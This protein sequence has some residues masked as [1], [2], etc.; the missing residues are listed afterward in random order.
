MRFNVVIFALAAIAANL[1]F[2]APKK[3]IA[4]RRPAKAAPSDKNLRVQ[5]LLDRAHFS[6]G[7]IDGVA[8]DNF[9]A[10]INAYR[11]ANRIRE[12]GEPGELTVQSLESQS[13]G[14]PTLTEYTITAQDVTGPFY[15]IPNDL[16]KQAE[17]PALGYTSP[18]EAIGEKFHVSPK[19][20]AR[21]NPG[22]TF[23]SAGEQIQVPNI[24]ID[25]P[26]GAVAKIFVSRSKRTV[27][28]V[29]AQGKTVAMYPATI[30][31]TH[32]P[33]PIGDWKV[34]R[35]VGN[36]TFYYNPDL[37]WNAPEADTK[38]TIKPGPNNPAGVVW[39]GLSKAHYGIH[40]TPEPGLV[41]K[42]ESHGCIRLTNWDAAE[43]GRLVKAGTPAILT[44]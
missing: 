33:L 38:A 4:P 42:V 34:T 24:N 30:G 20:L 1:A 39:I 2:A 29:D 18:I 22:K 21:I 31:S 9:R 15:R 5:V 19:L 44:E 36:P 23:S 37:F 14:A 41:G 43:L 12:T 25:P 28:A 13:N 10:A 3:S 35:V 8:G 6:P 7:E 16:L 11:S 26:A 40:G 27:E 32:D 17:L